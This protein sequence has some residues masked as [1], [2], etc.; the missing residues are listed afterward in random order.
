[1]KKRVE[2]KIRSRLRKE[3]AL[4]VKRYCILNGMEIRFGNSQTGAPNSRRGFLPKSV[5]RLVAAWRHFA[6]YFIKEPIQGIFIYAKGSAIIA[7]EPSYYM[8]YKLGADKSP[9][10]ASLKKHKLGHIIELDKGNQLSVAR[11]GSTKSQSEYSPVAFQWGTI[12][13]HFDE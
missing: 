1:M 9:I 13:N 7:N 6:R 12:V 2:K 11:V 4:F 10:Y 8:T 3:E 5:M